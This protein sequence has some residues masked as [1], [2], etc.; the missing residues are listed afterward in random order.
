MSYFTGYLPVV[1]FLLLAVVPSSYEDVFTAMV[2]LENLLMSEAETTSA[3]I[4][5]YIR[6]ESERLDQ[7]RSYA[8]KFASQKEGV[9]SGDTALYVSNPI[10]VICLQLLGRWYN[11][12]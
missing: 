6:V 1:A 7:L 8:E 4:D 11:N 10:N 3:I 9:E 2:D 12:P 5:Q